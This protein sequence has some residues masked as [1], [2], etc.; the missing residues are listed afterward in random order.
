MGNSSWGNGFHTG[1]EEGL[2]E[3]LTEGRTEGLIT[4]L[5]ITLVGSA[6]TAFGGYVFGKNGGARGLIEKIRG[7]HKKVIYDVIADA[8]GNNG[9]VLLIGDKF[10]IIKLDGDSVKIE[11]VGDVNNPYFVSRQFLTSISNFN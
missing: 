2:S 3:G 1:R 10:K 9:L 6:L 8:K 4:G 5:I 11:K 7:K